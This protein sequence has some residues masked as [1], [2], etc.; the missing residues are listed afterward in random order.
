L[1]AL[2]LASRAT[3]PVMYYTG[4]LFFIGCVLFNFLLIKQVYDKQQA[5]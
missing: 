3:D 2:Y 5:H 1:F 4:I